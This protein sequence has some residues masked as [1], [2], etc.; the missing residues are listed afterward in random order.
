MVEWAHDGFASGWNVEYWFLYELWQP[1]DDY[2][3]EQMQG[4]YKMNKTC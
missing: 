2:Q 3:S 4:Q 1:N